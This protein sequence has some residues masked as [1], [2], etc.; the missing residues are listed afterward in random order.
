LRRALFCVSTESGRYSTD[1]LKLELRGSVFRIVGTD[2]HRLSVVE[3][4]A[5]TEGSSTFSAL[6]FRSTA[7]ILSRLGLADE[8]RWVVF[9]TCGS[10]QEFNLFTLPVEPNSS[11]AEGKVSSRITRTF[12]PRHRSKPESSSGAKNCWKASRSS[13]PL[14]AKQKSRR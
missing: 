11:P 6:L 8:P 4:T 1:V 5:R 12:C 13:R 9:S 3:G 10:E 2:G 7:T 14:L